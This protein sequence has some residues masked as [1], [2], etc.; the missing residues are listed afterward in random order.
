MIRNGYWVSA[1]VVLNP[2]GYI[3]MRDGLQRMV[4]MVRNF[5]VNVTDVILNGQCEESK[6]K[7]T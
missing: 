6:F 4:S 1:N 5:G 3:T 2:E 7:T